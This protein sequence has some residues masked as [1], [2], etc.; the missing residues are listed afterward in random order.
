MSLPR[1]FSAQ[2]GPRL[3]H[4]SLQQVRAHFGLTQDW[5]AGF[6]RV[7]RSAVSMEESQGHGLPVAASLAMLPFY[8]GI[9]TPDGPAPEPAATPSPTN[10]AANRPLLEK[11]QQAL[12]LELRQLG[13]QQER[14][15]VRLRQVR[16]R[17]QTLP[18]LLMAL[19]PP[20]DDARPRRYLG[21]W[22]TDAPEQLRTDEAALA[23]LDLRQRVLEFELAEI[24][25]LLE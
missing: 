22:I 9:P 1:R 18:A 11:R 24:R 12:E 10:L 14:L 21:Y 15:R 6:L 3:S 19:P 20:P 23:L 16:L 8:L 4:N 13:R 25:K 5:L 7:P 17:L 2:R